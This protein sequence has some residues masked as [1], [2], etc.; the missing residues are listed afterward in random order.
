MKVEALDERRLERRVAKREAFQVHASAQLLRIQPLRLGRLFA[1]LDLRGVAHD[2]FDTLDFRLHLLH[3]LAEV[4]HL[5]HRRHERGEETRERQQGPRCEIAFHDKPDSQYQ[6]HDVGELRDGL[7]YRAQVLG[8]PRLVG[9]DVVISCLVARPPVEEGVFGAC[10][11]Y[12]LDHL[13]AVYPCGGQHAFHVC[14][15]TH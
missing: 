1:F 6:H 9:C 4:Y 5:V 11:L 15:G 14:A 7:G 13:H 12:G 3:C 8:Q 10:G 2:V